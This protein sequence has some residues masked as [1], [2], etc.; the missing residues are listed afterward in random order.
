ML[1]LDIP[2]GIGLWDEVGA[3]VGVLARLVAAGDIAALAGGVEAGSVA[4]TGTED[5]EVVLTAARR[6][7]NLE[8]GDLPY[9]AGAERSGGREGGEESSGEDVFELHLCYDGGIVVSFLRIEKDGRWK[10]RI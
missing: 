5:V 2:A 7:A 9:L 8:F 6:A 3:D 10:G 4:C 1:D